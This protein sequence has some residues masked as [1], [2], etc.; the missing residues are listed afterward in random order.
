MRGEGVVEDVEELHEAG[1]DIFW[2]GEVGG[3]GEAGLQVTEEARGA[4]WVV[5]GLGA[6]GVADAE[7]TRGDGVEVW[8]VEFVEVAGRVDEDG[9]LEGFFGEGVVT[10]GVVGEVVED[11]EGEHVAGGGDVGVPGEDGAIDDFDVGGVGGGGGLVEKGGL[12]GG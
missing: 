2:E 8:D 7:E 10:D 12:E 5:E 3:K 4:K 1:G 9:A 11:F 6:G